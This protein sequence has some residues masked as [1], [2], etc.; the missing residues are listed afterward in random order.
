MT[1][2][3]LISIKL[4]RMINPWNSAERKWEKQ[5]QQSWKKWKIYGT[6][7]CVRVT[8]IRKLYHCHDFWLSCTFSTLSFS[9]NIRGI[10]PNIT[11][12]NEEVYQKVC[13]ICT[14]Q[15]TYNIYKTVK[16]MGKVPS[17]KCN[18]GLR[19]ENCNLWTWF[20]QFW[21]EDKIFIINYMLVVVIIIGAYIRFLT[22]F[23][24]LSLCR[25]YIQ[26]FIFLECVYL[27]SIFTCFTIVWNRCVWVCVC[28]S[29]ASLP[30]FPSSPQNNLDFNKFS[31]SILAIICV[32][33]MTK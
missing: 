18:T 11:Y 1:S 33:C 29:H 24:S 16:V 23:L 17:N 20:Y 2:T 12:A 13:L 21:R 4:V 8:N 9:L 3:H 5:K 15:H 32:V 6:I 25:F 19:V 30:L 22:H 31:S 14:A 10:T 7:D 27:Y 28:V 26:T